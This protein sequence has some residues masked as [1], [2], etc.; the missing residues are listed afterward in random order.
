M[1]L[2]CKTVGIKIGINYTTIQSTYQAKEN[3]C[4]HIASHQGDG[5]CVAMKQFMMVA[6]RRPM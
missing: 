5:H 2:F 1:V 6:V 3:E 4:T